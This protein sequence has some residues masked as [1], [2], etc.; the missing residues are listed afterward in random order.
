MVTNQSQ[1]DA[2]A[3]FRLGARVDR[4]TAA[5]PQTAA[6]TIFTISGGRVLFSLIVGE[7]T[8]VIQ[9]QANNTKLKLVPTTGSTVDL[10]AV[11]DITALEV[12]GKLVVNGTAAT[13]LVQANAGA[14]I[15]ETVPV[16]CAIGNLQLD[17]AASNTGSIKWSVWYVPIDD[18]ALVVAA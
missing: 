16:I 11:K 3:M 12:G 17:C 10:C 18:G 7:V 8:V 14:I 6:G 2:A 4:A 5:L 13:A 1:R 9:T 15:A